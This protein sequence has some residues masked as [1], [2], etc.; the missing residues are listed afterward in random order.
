MKLGNIKS[1]KVETVDPNQDPSKTASD[2]SAQEVE[3]DLDA[4]FGD[5]NET[6]S[7]S[8]SSSPLDE[9]FISD[10]ADPAGEDVTLDRL[11]NCVPSLEKILATNEQA[12]R[13]L[14]VIKERYKNTKED[15]IALRDNYLDALPY[16]NADEA[17]MLQRKIELCNDGI[18][19]CDTNDL[20]VDDTIV[21]NDNVHDQEM[22]NGVDLTGDGVIGDP[23]R[24]T[25][26]G[27]IYDEDGMV[28]YID[29]ATGN[30]VTNP[31]MF[32]DYEAKVLEGSNVSMIEASARIEES[33]GLSTDHTSADVYLRVD[34]FSETHGL[35][36]TVVDVSI[37][38]WIWVPAENNQPKYDYES[39]EHTYEFDTSLWTTDGGFR[40]VCPEDKS[41]YV[42]VRVAEV[43]VFSEQVMETID[44]KPL[45]NTYV[46]FLDAGGVK[47]ARLRFEGSFG[48]GPMSS[49]T[50]EGDFRASFGIGFNGNYRCSDIIFDASRYQSTCRHIVDG[51]EGKLGLERPAG[52]CKAYDENLALFQG[53]SFESTYATISGEGSDATL[54]E[55][56]TIEHNDSDGSFG[57]A[58]PYGSYHD[59]YLTEEPGDNESL[60]GFTT[61]VFVT[62]LR[63][64]LRGSDDADIF[65]IQEVNKTSESVE[66]YKLPNAEPVRKGDALYHTVVKG[67]GG[68]NI[69]RARKGDL[70]ARDIS[71]AW[72][73]ASSKDSVAIDV[74]EDST[75]PT[76]ESSNDN[77]YK[78]D[79]KNFV[80]IDGAG[81]STLYNA[82]EGEISKDAAVAEGK[83]FQND[84]YKLSGRISASTPGDP[85]IVG[86][87]LTDSNQCGGADALNAAID[88]VI[89]GD[90]CLEDA[91]KGFY[92]DDSEFDAPTEWES[93][94]GTGGYAAEQDEEM[95]QFFNDM[96]GDL[97]EFQIEMIEEQ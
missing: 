61:G 48:T 49:T 9:Y 2:F 71:F 58:D 36:D 59:R 18:L 1:F 20:K 26:L 94:Y 57:D 32:P 39:D 78:R 47:I 28:H 93:I 42:Q 89:Q 95:D 5:L 43:Q 38:E 75:S 86:V 74:V 8:S 10:P 91:I 85:D 13:Y 92:N 46:E 97:S 77:G 50:A 37:P 72:V 17:Q 22:A 54:G 7:S 6:D 88:S 83:A 3:E 40:Q 41:D 44:G 79:P 80:W 67:G 19:K 12:A 24:S 21:R 81:E 53:A 14:D 96:F 65:D 35:F 30:V 52:D 68:M 63:G 4:I 90:V 87:T 29:R 45:W 55:P 56:G 25:S 16:V 64:I 84:Y 76:V 60:Q 70:L 34:D 33:L 73:E 23:S 82:D 27:V 51:L 69:L 15:L 31:M 66:D 11:A 62:G